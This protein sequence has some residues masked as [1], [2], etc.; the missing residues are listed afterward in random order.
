VNELLQLRVHGVLHNVVTH[1]RRQATST[2]PR[3]TCGSCRARTHRVHQHAIVISVMKVRCN[4]RPHA[5]Y[6]PAAATGRHKTITITTTITSLATHIRG[7]QHATNSY[8]NTIR[9]QSTSNRMPSRRA[10]STAGET[11]SLYPLV[12]Q[13]RRHG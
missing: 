13:R 4:A 9:N 3:T 1:L 2:P 12:I 11:P 10:A 5:E 6:V 7:A 8:H